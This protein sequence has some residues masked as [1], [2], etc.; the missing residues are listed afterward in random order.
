MPKTKE[1]KQVAGRFKTK[2]SAPVRLAVSK[3]KVMPEIFQGRTVPFAKETV[4]KITKEGYDISQEPIVVW[5]S[6]KKESIVISGHSRTEAA[7]RLKLKEIPVKYFKGTFDDA[8][9][10]AV[11][12]SNRSGKAEGI[13]SDIKAFARA[14]QRGYN[15]DFMLGIF[16]SES[17]IQ[18]LSFLS[19]L[20]PKGRFIEILS[21]ESNSKSF[22]YLIRNAAWTGQL[23]KQY[24]ELTDEH[25]KEIFNFFYKSDIGLKI[26]KDSFFDKVKSKVEKPGF[27]PK[28]PLRLLQE[29]DFEYLSESEPGVKLYNQL[30]SQE[31]SLHDQ[32]RRK[33][34][35]MAYAMNTGEETL[36]KK[37]ENEAH[38]L[39]HNARMK[40][41]EIL[42]LGLKLGKENERMK[43]GGL[44]N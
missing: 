27:N 18:T 34:Q 39:R 33:L 41:I 26:K 14:Q 29:K 37:L 5:L 11:I 19:K 16:K 38:D 42:R 2:F 10:Y 15:K 3:I 25:E 32:H 24:P 36:A 7:K 17:Y 4:D 9:D 40:H 43:T 6:P 8:V 20:D 21:N 13:E 44:F 30:I 23:R 22:P 31:N 12:E 35:L 1:Q 28:K